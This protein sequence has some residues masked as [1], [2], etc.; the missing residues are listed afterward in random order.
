MDVT[1]A[2]GDLV[3]EPGIRRPHYP[4][5]FRVVSLK[6]KRENEWRKDWYW[7]S[8]LHGLT[9]QQANLFAAAPDLLAALELTIH[10]LEA[11]VER[12]RDAM[13]RYPDDPNGPG[14]LADDEK[15]LSLALAAIAK[16]RGK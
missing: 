1:F 16:A 8:I 3:V 14:A 15:I 4:Q 11:E 2:P 13:E 12:T 6:E 10:I 7:P 9:L 5:D